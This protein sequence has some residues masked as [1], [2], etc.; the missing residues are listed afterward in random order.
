M[1]VS[2]T[3]FA[4]SLNTN[5]ANVATQMAPI[6]QAEVEGVAA[7]LT[8]LAQRQDLMNHIIKLANTTAVTP[9]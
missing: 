9:A 1:A 4:T 7:A 6:T 8:A 2:V 3:A 5:A